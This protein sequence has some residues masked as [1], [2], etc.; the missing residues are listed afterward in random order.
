MK[1]KAQEYRLNKPEVVY[2]HL[3]SAACRDLQ[4]DQN[5]TNLV[6][7]LAR[8][9]DWK[10]L[11]RFAKNVSSQMYG[12]SSEHFR[13][14]QLSSLIV[15]VPFPGVG[16]NVLRDAAWTKF[17][18]AEHSCK[19]TNQRFLALER[20][21]T[22]GAKRFPA[23][24]YQRL[25]RA[26]ELILRVLGEKPDLSQ[27]YELARFG[28]G[29]TV[30][31]GGD[32]THLLRKVDALTVVPS[33]A[34]YAVGLLWSHAQLREQFCD[35]RG[36]V[37]CLDPEKFRVEVLRRLN[38]CDYNK[39]AFVP[40]NAETDRTIG[41]E[42]AVTGLIQLGFGNL[43]AQLLKTVARIDL[44]DQTRNQALARA[45]SQGGHDPIVTIDLKGASDS[46]ARLVVKFFLP[47]RWHDALAACRSPEYLC[48]VKGVRARYEKFT[49]MGMA[50]ASRS[51]L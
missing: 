2:Y 20:A 22:L 33:A 28:P 8:A 44:T 25:L 27:V 42:G 11:I 9:R 37:H 34:P 13:W 1:P 19:R 21:T 26:R 48:K 16:K 51:K 46:L 35:T 50:S 38:Y 18:Q 24:M 17:L 12:D 31:L 49:S 5:T 47:G 36:G 4:V 14:A 32:A 41:A 10:A 39:I 40:K 6:L 45:G 30:D 15:K 7:G 23:A 29:S 3:L 43:I